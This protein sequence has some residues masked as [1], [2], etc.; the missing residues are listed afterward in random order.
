MRICSKEFHELLSASRL[1][2]LDTHPMTAKE[3]LLDPRLVQTLKSKDIIEKRS[4]ARAF[5]RTYI[6][7]GPGRKYRHYLKKWGWA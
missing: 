4:K 1:Y 5:H 2:E 6:I 3:M 7:W